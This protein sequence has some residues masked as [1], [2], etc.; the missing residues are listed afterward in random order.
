[1][2]GSMVDIQS[3]TVDNR[4]GKKKKKEDSN[5]SGKIEFPHLLRRAAINNY[6]YYTLLWPTCVA[7]ADIIFSSC[8][9]FFLS[10][11]FFFLFSS[12]ILSRRKLDVYHTSIHDVALVRI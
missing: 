4:R 9:F 12:P 7:D 5:H 11:S 6:I 10:S 8:G 1:M 3:A 2:C